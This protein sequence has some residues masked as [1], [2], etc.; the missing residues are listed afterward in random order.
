MKGIQLKLYTHEHR[1]HKGILL[2]EWLLNRAR[3]LELHGGS[4]F[5]ALAGFGRDGVI[6][7]EHFFELASN[8]PVEVVFI[9]T[10]EECDSFLDLL[11]NE[12]LN[13]LFV[14]IPVEFGVINHEEKGP[15][16]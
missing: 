5:R 10:Q 2:Y 16:S 6:E 11:R 8:V 1:K 14:K 3:E 12:K 13:I 7:E 9:L 4:A 15:K